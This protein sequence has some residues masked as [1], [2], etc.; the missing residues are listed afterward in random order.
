MRYFVAACVLGVIALSCHNENELESYVPL[1]LMEY[2]VPLTILAP[3]SAEVKTMDMG[4]MK[5]VTVKKDPDYYVQ[6]YASEATTRDVAKVLAEQLAEVKNGR[7]FKA[8]VREEPA[9]FIYQTA[10]DSSN[11]NYGFRYVR[12]QGDNEFIFQTGLIGTFTLDEVER[13][14]KAVQGTE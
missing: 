13:M 8:I 5:D 2:G 11:T 4:F 14:Y 6:I 10:V 12:I 1:N 7:Y 9:G 3:D